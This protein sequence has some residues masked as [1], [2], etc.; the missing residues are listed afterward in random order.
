VRASIRA[1]PR[2]TLTGPRHPRAPSA[3][4][5]ASAATVGGEPGTGGSGAG[6]V[7][8]GPAYPPFHAGVPAGS[9]RTLVPL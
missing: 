4:V 6:G 8:S 2:E 9:G 1:R 5:V 3:E 7:A